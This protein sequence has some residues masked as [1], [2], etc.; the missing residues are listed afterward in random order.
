MLST[1]RV[2][3]RKAALRSTRLNVI[4]AASTWANVAQGPPV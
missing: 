4:R 1:L 3:S 2:A